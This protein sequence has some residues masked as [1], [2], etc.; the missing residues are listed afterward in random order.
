MRSVNMD[1]LET[2]LRKTGQL[3]EQAHELIYKASKDSIFAD[4]YF[5][6]SSSD[7]C[8]KN[9]AIQKFNPDIKEFEPDTDYPQTVCDGLGIARTRMNALIEEYQYNNKVIFDTLQ[10]HVDM[11]NGEMTIPEMVI[12]SNLGF[13]KV[14]GKQDMNMNMEYY[15]SVPW[16]MITKAGGRKLFGGKEKDQNEIGEYDPDKKYRYVNLIIKGDAENY[17]VSLGKKKK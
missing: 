16:K 1:T 8:T 15:I 13:L 12:N 14:S 2:S 5:N 6:P 7:A 10:N 4:I 11:T 3:T 9:A 17:S